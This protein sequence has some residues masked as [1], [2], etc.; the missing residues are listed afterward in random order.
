MKARFL[1]MISYCLLLG[2]PLAAGGGKIVFSS[3]RDG[4]RAIFI[5][6]E[7]G[8]NETNLT[9]DLSHEGH[10]V[11]APNGRRI[12]FLKGV[13]GFEEVYT[14]NMD[15]S[16]VRQITSIRSPLALN[17][18]DWHPDGSRIVFAHGRGA[19]LYQVNP[20]GTGLTLLPNTSGLLTFHPKYSF[21]GSRLYTQR[22]PSSAFGPD[23]VWV[24]NPDGSAEF[25]LTSL[26]EL[27]LP[28]EIRVNGS[29]KLTVSRG[30]FPD[31]RILLL[32]LD[33][34]SA[35]DISASQKNEFFPHA[36]RRGPENELAFVRQGNDGVFNIWKM[37]VDGSGQVQLT[38]EGG[39]E[40]FWW[41]PPQLH[42]SGFQSP[43]DAGPVTVQKHRALPLKAEIIDV[44]G[45]PLSDFDIQALPVL[46]VLF[47]PAGGGDA[48]DVTDDALPAGEGTDGNQFAFSDGLWRF[49][50]KT[51]SYS[52]PGTY[53]ITMLS[54]DE[55]EYFVEGCSAQF[56]IDP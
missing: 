21:D 26:G 38:T 22:R 33:A 2:Q 31:S 52:A 48:I 28:T 39:E 11:I 47:D 7:N 35:T 24:S 45:L 34:S 4:S 49:N 41:A 36:P 20:D 32:E 9:P 37:N 5:M 3:I 12:A 16:D 30:F 29:V 44:N 54:G 18:I 56:V 23:E 10:P 25:Q 1:N 40:P 50:L 27:Q 46:Q 42:C 19:K 13:D 8:S 14:M 51:R 15:G 43:L 55:S 53:T 17:G 6:E